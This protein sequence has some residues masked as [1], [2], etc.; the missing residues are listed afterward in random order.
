MRLYLAFTEAIEEQR[1]QGATEIFSV[2]QAQIDDLIGPTNV[3]NTRDFRIFLQYGKYRNLG[4]GTNASN[5]DAM[6]LGSLLKSANEQGLY[7]FPAW[8]YENITLEDLIRR[9]RGL[10]VMSLCDA[11]NLGMANDEPAHGVLSVMGQQVIAISQKL[12]G[13]D[14]E[15]FK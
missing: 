4:D 11:T 2:L 13:L 6:T 1:Q 8:P 9:V 14:L 7:P 10:E 12:N 5:C 15:D 3:C